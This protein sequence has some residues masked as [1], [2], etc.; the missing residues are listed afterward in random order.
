MNTTTSATGAPPTVDL[1]I[2][3]RRTAL[4]VSFRLCFLTRTG[5]AILVAKASWSTALTASATRATATA[6]LASRSQ[7]SAPRVTALCT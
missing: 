1:V 2:G 6:R 3:R 5:P 4:L 7:R